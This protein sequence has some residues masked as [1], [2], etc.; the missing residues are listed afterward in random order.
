[1]FCGFLFMAY[2]DKKNMK[3][4]KKNEND[5]NNNTANDVQISQDNDTIA[6]MKIDD[7]NKNNNENAPKDNLNKEKSESNENKEN[8]NDTASSNK[9][10][11]K[12]LKEKIK[13]KCVN[14]KCRGYYFPQFLL[15]LGFIGVNLALLI[16]SAWVLHKNHKDK[17][18]INN[19]RKIESDD[20]IT[21]FLN[22]FREKCE[23]SSLIIPTISLLGSS[24]LLHLI[25]IIIFIIVFCSGV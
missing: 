17:R 8:N 4:E 1:M 15:S 13:D 2:E 25:G 19:L 12:N 24:I 14:C 23:I 18:K 7:L 22:E 21:G 16:Y 5:N 6:D 9:D 20:F 10:D 3:T 11:K